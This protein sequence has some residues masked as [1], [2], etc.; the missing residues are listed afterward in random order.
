MYINLCFCEVVLWLYIIALKERKE[1]I[2]E[3]IS[4]FP[5]LRLVSES[6]NFALG[7]A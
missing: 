5:L 4:R 3:T 2:A 1:M 6:V 7:E